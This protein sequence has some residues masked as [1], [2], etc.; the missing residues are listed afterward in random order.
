MPVARGPSREARRAVII[1][2]VGVAVA[3]VLLGLVIA[4][5]NNGGGQVQ[6]RLGDER[7]QDLE[8]EKTARGITKGGPILFPDVGGGTRDIFINHLGDDP[9]AGWIAFDARRPGTDRNCTLQWQ[10]D[11]RVFRDPCTGADVAADGTGLRQYPVVVNARGILIVDLNADARAGSTTVAPGGT[12][13]GGPTTTASGSAG[14]T[15]AATGTS[16]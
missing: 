10:A 8:A 12:F 11:R 5:A 6:L 9:K 3:V 2:A 13:A 14:S 15:T 7:F 1:G 16:R 4:L